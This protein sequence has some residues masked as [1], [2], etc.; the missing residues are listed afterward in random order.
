V[1]VLACLQGNANSSR[2][3]TISRALV[4]LFALI[5]TAFGIE[6]FFYTDYTPGI[7]SRSFVA[8]WIPMRLFLGYLTG[9]ILL[10]VGVMML[11]KRHERLAACV[12]GFTVL[13]AAITTY[14]F[15]MYAHAGNFGELTNTMKDVALAGG[16]SLWDPRSLRRKM[17][18]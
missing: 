16:A 18:P 3:Q 5:V 15:R 12:L 6:H 11:R 17:T 1:F 7:P 8:F 10:S 9:A 14:L 2:S 13:I 4:V